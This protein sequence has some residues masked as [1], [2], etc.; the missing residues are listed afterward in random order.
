[1][2][3]S[4]GSSGGITS[5]I[6]VTPMADIMLVLLIIFMIT[7]PLLTEGIVVNKA[8]ATNPTEAVEVEAKNVIEVTL[9][10]NSEIY[11]NSVPI[12]PEDVAEQLMELGELAGDLPLFLKSDVAAPYGLVVDIVNKAR[13]AGVEKIG[14]IVDEQDRTFF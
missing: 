1:M 11:I 12:P 9:T 10:R 5:E 7:A 8:K 14:L 3:M 13:D 4:G 2:S 6:N